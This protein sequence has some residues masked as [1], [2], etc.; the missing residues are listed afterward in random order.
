MPLDHFFQQKISDFDTYGLGSYAFYGE[1]AK[2]T[3][4]VYALASNP[5]MDSS[6][7]GQDRSCNAAPSDGLNAA[8]AGI[9]LEARVIAQ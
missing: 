4:K 7:W 3:W 6:Q 8:N 1:D 5:L 9:R 2:G